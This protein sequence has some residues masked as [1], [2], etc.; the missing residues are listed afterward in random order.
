MRLIDYAPAVLEALKAK[1]PM[2]QT[3]LT[4]EVWGT[5]GTG[6]T[7]LTQVLFPHMVAKKQMVLTQRGRTKV[8]SL[9]EA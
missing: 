6:N 8:Y 7:R 3:T 9:P 2:N 5:S 4:T 1:G